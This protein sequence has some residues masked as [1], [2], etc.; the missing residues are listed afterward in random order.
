MKNNKVELC[1]FESSLELAEIK[2]SY[3]R[4]KTNDVKVTNSLT[5]FNLLFP[6][7]DKD[8]IELQEQFYML[9]L[10]RANLA[11]GWINISK[12]GA[13]GTIVDPKIVFAIALQANSCC[14]ILSHNHPSGNLSPSDS[15]IKLTQNLLASAKLLEINILDHIIVNSCEKYYSFAD[16]GKLEFY[17]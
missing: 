15:D 5:A 9:L 12:G 10:N 1:H 8:I 3:K 17:K 7:Y 13:T 11:I 2:V 6:L 4:G 16:E 14:I